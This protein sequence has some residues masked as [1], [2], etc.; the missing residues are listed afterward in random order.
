MALYPFH[1]PSHPQIEG[2]IH[3]LR[4]GLLQKRFV[5]GFQDEDETMVHQSDPFHWESM[6]LFLTETGSLKI[7]EECGYLE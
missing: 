1:M 7:E 4:D 6:E 2:Y 3:R 5:I